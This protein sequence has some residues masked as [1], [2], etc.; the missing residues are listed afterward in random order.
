MTPAEALQKRDRAG[1]DGG[2]RGAVPHR[3]IDII[4]PDRTADNGYSS[5]VP[6][7]PR[8]TSQV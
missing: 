1:L 6:L 4:L 3:V 5:S 2:P 7:S 8:A